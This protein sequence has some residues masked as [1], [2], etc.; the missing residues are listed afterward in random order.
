MKILESEAKKKLI[1]KR[2]RLLLKEKEWSQ[3]DLA[4]AMDVNKSYISKIL[5]G[6]QNM[7]LEGITSIEKALGKRIID[8]L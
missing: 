6:D 4:E 2:I 3:Q 7:T 5:A 8:I 1:A